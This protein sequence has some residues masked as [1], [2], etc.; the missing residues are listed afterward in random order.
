VTVSRSMRMIWAVLVAG[1]VV[2]LL[3]GVVL[4]QTLVTGTVTRNA[5]LRAGPGTSYAVVGTAAAGAT[6]VIVGENAAGDWYELEDGQWIAA[7]LVRT[8]D[9]APSVATARPTA[10]ATTRPSAVVSNRD[11]Q[12]YNS[13]ISESVVTMGSALEQMSALMGTPRLTSDDW[14]FDLALQFVIIR[15][16]HEQLMV[17]K[18]PASLA[19]VH[20]QVLS[21]TQDCNDATYAIAEG[22]DNFD[23]DELERGGGLLADCADKTVV[24]TERL[25]QVQMSLT[26]TPRPRATPTRRP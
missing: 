23:V 24:L 15:Q 19:S 5:N 18:P 6:V 9:A 16:A 4:A 8:G 3:A 7:F 11:W 12:L 22:L 13:Q 21:A 2:I 26:P 14:I 10:V 25:R 1:I 20:Q 17:V